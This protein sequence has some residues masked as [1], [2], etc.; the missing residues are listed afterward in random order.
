VRGG[1]GNF[2]IARS[3]EYDNRNRMVWRQDQLGRE[4]TYQYTK[5]GD[6]ENVTFPNGRE[7]HMTYDHIGRLIEQELPNGTVVTY[8]RDLNGNI[9]SAVRDGSHSTT[10]SVQLTYDPRD[11]ITSITTAFPDGTSSMSAAFTYDL[12]GNNI[13]IATDQGSQYATGFEYDELDHVSEIY[14][15]PTSHSGFKYDKFTMR[16]TQMPKKNKPTALN[17]VVYDAAGRGTD[18]TVTQDGILADGERSI[19]GVYHL[20]YDA[21]TKQLITITRDGDDDHAT[22]YAY[23][24]YG[25]LE[26][27]IFP[28]GTQQRLHYDEASRVVEVE[29]YDAE[30]LPGPSYRQEYNGA[31]EVSA[32]DNGVARI[33]YD[34][35]YDYASDDEMVRITRTRSRTEPSTQHIYLGYDSRLER[36]MDLD[37]SNNESLVESYVWYPFMTAQLE[38]VTNPGSSG[39][40]VRNV[41]DGI[42][43]PLFSHLSGVTTGA[44]TYYEQSASIDQYRQTPFFRL[45]PVRSVRDREHFKEF[46]RRS[47]LESHGSGSVALSYSGPGASAFASLV[48]ATAALGRRDEA[49]PYYFSFGALDDLPLPDYKDPETLLR[50]TA[51]FRQPLSLAGARPQDTGAQ[52]QPSG[53]DIDPGNLS[54]LV[55]PSGQRVKPLPGDAIPPGC[56]N[57]GCAGTVEAEL[58]GGS[59]SPGT[60]PWIIQR[61]PARTE[62]WRMYARTPTI[63]LAMFCIAASS[64]ATRTIRSLT[65]TP[66][67]IRTA[68]SCRA[69]STFFRSL[70]WTSRGPAC[71][72]TSSAHT[73]TSSTTTARWASV[74]VTTTTS[75]YNCARAA[76]EA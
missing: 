61:R 30:G 41:L 34:Y 42:G 59:T 43:G 10:D 62:A 48:A 40:H 58:D 55:S 36:V 46:A 74:G 7:M 52:L 72:S 3:F 75:G 53:A 35:D 20:D 14:Y 50:L 6:P 23:D 47:N 5:V 16:R 18:F 38:T 4:W 76:V 69:A 22:H 26:V 27:Q 15:T 9:T 67:T 24:A 29:T 11:L 56:I 51:A 71:P 33:E 65:R 13:S 70:T 8:E 45:E 57:V 66:Q 19:D 31:G 60:P 12:N 73:G 49:P 32:V 54:L 28:D 63:A 2:G 68:S 37:T 64:I 44:N 17:G 1:G 39:N 25:R 21:T